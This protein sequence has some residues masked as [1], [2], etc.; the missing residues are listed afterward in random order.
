MSER[1]DKAIETICVPV[2]YLHELEELKKEQDN[3]DGDTEK[4]QS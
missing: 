3:D 1:E 4:K 2:T